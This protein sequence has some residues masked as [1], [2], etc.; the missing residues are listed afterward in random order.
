MDADPSSSL[1]LAVGTVLFFLLLVLSASFSGAETA[2]T[3]MTKL[4]VKRLFTEGDS[5]YGKLELWLL[6]PRRYLTTILIGNNVVNV[7]VSILASL[8]ARGYLQAFGLPDSS[9]TASAAA[10][11]VVTFF[12]L[13]FGEI[14]PKNYC[15]EHAVDISLLVIHPLEW[16]YRLLK[17]F[18]VFFVFISSI[19]I[20]MTGGKTIRELP[21]LTEDEIR[22]LIEVSEREGVLEQGEREMI[23]SIIDFGDRLVQ[24]IMTPR[25][26]I[27]ALDAEDQTLEDARRVVVE[28]GHSRILVYKHDLDQS[29]GILYAKDLLVERDEPGDGAILQSL[30]R[31]CMVVPKGKRVNDLLQAFRSEKTHIAVVVDEY[32]CTAG[33]VTIED[34]LEEIVGDIQDEFDSEQPPYE[35]QPDGAILLD[36]KINLDELESELGIKLELP[37]MEFETLGGFITS[38]LGEVP[39]VGAE[40]TFEAYSFTILAGDIRKI[41]RVRM[42]E[43]GSADDDATVSQDAGP[44]G[45]TPPS[46]RTGV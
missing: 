40:F 39:E 36:A 45:K 31:P 17:P 43:V 26:D 11:L 21:L 20:R 27:K 32:G 9:A 37:E 7:A 4:R 28:S 19:V 30:L 44:G 42:L 16:T 18:V 2:L 33:I 34:V 22:T 12:L 1:F 29:L 23:H 41:D 38:H 25:V 24:E 15:K 5:R 14:V 6:N 46:D 10:F 13:T 35:V 8:L 3:S